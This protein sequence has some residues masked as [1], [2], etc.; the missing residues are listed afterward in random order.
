MIYLSSF[1]FLSRLED[2]KFF[3]SSDIKVHQNCYTSEYPFVMFRDRGLPEKFEFQDITVFCGNNGN[4]KST[5]LNVIAEALAVNRGSLFNRSEYFDNYTELCSYE[6]AE[7]IPS[8]SAIITSDDVFEG[9]LD[10]RRINEGIDSKRRVLID[11]WIENRDESADAR[12]H[13]IEDYDRWKRIVNSRRKK[14]SQSKFLRSNL[15]G[16]I[17]ERSNG[18]SALS[19][20]VNKIQD[21]ALYL[22]DEPENS[23]S[24][25]NQLQLKYFLEDCV[26]SHGCQFIIST[27]SPFLLSLRGARIYDI[28]SVP[29]R[30]CKWTDLECVKVYQEFFE[31][32]SFLFQK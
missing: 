32:K 3:S 27:H 17:T 1:R 18:E 30:V 19:L 10:I 22:L 29:M 26:K 9:L 24:P 4:R 20:F 21:N 11:E 31:K 7:R 12:L 16:N 13:G 28:D 8:H 6:L 14:E 15:R 23:L 5:I 2:E 25:S